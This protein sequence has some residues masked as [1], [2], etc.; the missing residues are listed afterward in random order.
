VNE[1]AYDQDL[2]VATGWAPHVRIGV[3][4]LLFPLLLGFA[5][6][7]PWVWLGGLGI[8]LGLVADVIA[9]AWWRARK[10]AIFPAEVSIPE[11]AVLVV[12]TAALGVVA[13]LA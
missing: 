3:F 7:T 5:V 10:G 1:L 8:V 6:L 11:L 13:F 4:A 9:L 12:A 2:P